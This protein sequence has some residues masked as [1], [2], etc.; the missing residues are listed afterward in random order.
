M[1]QENVIL[2]TYTQSGAALVVT[3]SAQLLLYFIWLFFTIIFVTVFQA[4]NDWSFLIFAS[5]WCVFWLLSYGQHVLCS[6][7]VPFCCTMVELLQLWSSA[8][9]ETVLLDISRDENGGKRKMGQEKKAW[10]HKLYLPVI[11]IGNVKP[12][13]NETLSTIL[14]APHC[15]TACSVP[16]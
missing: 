3:Q 7:G 11:I 4:W 8:V 2:K 13:A 16:I 6:S 10:K 1:Q 12:Q 15:P 14:S 5:F 9:A